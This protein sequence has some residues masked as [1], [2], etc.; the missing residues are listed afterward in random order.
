MSTKRKKKKGGKSSIKYHGKAAD[1]YSPQHQDHDIFGG[2]DWSSDM[3][4]D[5]SPGGLMSPAISA[6]GKSGAR[7]AARRPSRPG[8][9]PGRKP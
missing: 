8:S 5:H 4:G 9:R 6:Q 3:G 7:S 1:G 2:S